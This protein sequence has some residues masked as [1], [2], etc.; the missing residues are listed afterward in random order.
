MYLYTG[1]PAPPT[2]VTAVQ[3][4]PTYVSVS[5]TAPHSGGPVSRYDIYYGVN[6]VP[7]T[8]GGCLPFEQKV[9]AS[10]SAI[11][12]PMRTVKITQYAQDMVCHTV[13]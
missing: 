4:G 13:S 3:S 10:V 12:M 6:G 9:L 11:Y 8:S 5:W 7:S 1:P 2:G